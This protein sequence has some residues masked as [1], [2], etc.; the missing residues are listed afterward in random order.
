M[1]H[2]PNYVNP[3][4]AAGNSMMG[5]LHLTQ[6]QEKRL[7]FGIYNLPVQS[8]IREL[9]TDRIG[10]L[11]SVSGTVTRTSQVRPELLRGV[12][13]CKACGEIAAGEVEQ[14]FKY[15]E[16]S[17]AEREYACR[18]KMISQPCVKVYF[19][20]TSQT[21]NYCWI[22]QHLLIGKSCVFR[23]IHLKFQQVV[24]HVGR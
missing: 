8:R 5:G 24:C 11:S 17:M 21:G 19:V 12:F 9:R 16:V 4:L 23:K 22:D 14:Q 3:A 1:M 13:R 10:K 18:T 7:N 2:V 6:Q 20:K 15:T